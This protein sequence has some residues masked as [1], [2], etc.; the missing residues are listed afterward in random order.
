MSLLR[1]NIRGIDTSLQ[2]G[3]S[4][5]VQVMFFATE[6]NGHVIERLGGVS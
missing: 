4:S 1:A 6:A 5:Q 3:G 2:L